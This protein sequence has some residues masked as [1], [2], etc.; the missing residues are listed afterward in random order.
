M[1]SLT[2]SE[3]RYI[4][5]NAATKTAAEIA[6]AIGVEE[7]TVTKF[8]YRN[9]ITLLQVQEPKLKRPK[10]EYSNHSP[11]RIASPGLIK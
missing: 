5:Q 3:M 7:I 1:Y 11:M 10:A 9:G 4:R 6:K 2:L 8:C